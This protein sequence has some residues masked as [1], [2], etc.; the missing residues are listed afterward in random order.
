MDKAIDSICHATLTSMSEAESPESQV[1][2]RVGD[3]AQTVLN[4]VDCLIHKGIAKVKLN[5]D[6]K[7]IK[8]NSIIFVFHTSW[9]GVWSESAAAWGVA[10]SSLSS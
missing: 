1:G 9:V 2:G 7:K 10:P 6:K 5:G 8:K 4:S 3:G